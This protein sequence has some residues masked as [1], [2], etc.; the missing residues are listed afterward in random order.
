MDSLLGILVSANTVLLIP[1]FSNGMHLL[2]EA[3]CLLRSFRR[4][5]IRWVIKAPEG[6]RER[7]WPT[8]RGI[9]VPGRKV[10]SNT[11]YR[12]QAHAEMLL[13]RIRSRVYKL[14]PTCPAL[15]IFQNALSSDLTDGKSLVWFTSVEGRLG[16]GLSCCEWFLQC[17]DEIISR[18]PVS[19]PLRQK[20]R[21]SSP[22]Y[23]E[24]HFIKNT[25][26]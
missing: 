9:G 4:W 20:G 14:I 11:S 16:L 10:S 19:I 13:E 8:S 24:S 22:F 5:R 1:P 25:V 2:P 21:I 12:S 26:H 3:V 15:S 18:R 7:Q 17:Y 6:R 23:R